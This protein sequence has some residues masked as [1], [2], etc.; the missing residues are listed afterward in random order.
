MALIPLSSPWFHIVLSSVTSLI[1]SSSARFRR[2]R[3][4][5]LVLGRWGWENNVDQGSSFRVILAFGDFLFFFHRCSSPHQ[6][7]HFRR[8]PNCLLHPHHRY[9][10]LLSQLAERAARRLPRSCRAFLFLLLPA[11]FENW[12]REKFN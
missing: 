5:R 7:P 4:E 6:P 11:I 3:L 12:F 1:A 8:P 2:A 9:L 10:L